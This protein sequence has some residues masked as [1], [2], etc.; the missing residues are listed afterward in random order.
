MVITYIFLI[1]FQ[2]KVDQEVHLIPRVKKKLLKKNMN[3]D[4]IDKS[5]CRVPWL[6][7]G[8]RKTEK[9]QSYK[10]K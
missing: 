3:P 10:I 5:Y 2:S 9:Q 4:M 7:Y 8:S 6:M 1:F